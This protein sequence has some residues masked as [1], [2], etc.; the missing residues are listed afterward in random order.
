MITGRRDVS[1]RDSGGIGLVDDCGQRPT[2]LKRSRPR[3]A[4]CCPRRT[5]GRGN[6]GAAVDHGFT[7]VR[8]D[9]VGDHRGGRDPGGRVGRRNRAVF[10]V[11][12][13]RDVE[14][15]AD[16]GGLGL[17]T[18]VCLAPLQHESV[19]RIIVLNV[20]VRQVDSFA[21]GEHSDQRHDDR[22]A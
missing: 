21:R 8:I 18:V 16:G 15:A 7:G 13:R 1:D 2:L 11:V 17:R 10:G 14:R 3:V 20:L 5:A 19:R 6:R 4:G 9:D 12:N 22:Q